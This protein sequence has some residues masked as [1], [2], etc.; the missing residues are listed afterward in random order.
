MD[1]DRSDVLFVGLGAT[2]VCY[3]RVLLPA[4][5]LGADYVGFYGEP[6]KLHYATGLVGGQSRVPDLRDYKLVVIQQPKG[7]E[8]LKIIEALRARGTVVCFEVDDYLHS[9]GHQADHAFRDAFTKRDLVEYERCMRAC[10][11]LI[12]STPYLASAY[13]PFN[14]RVYVCRN[15]IDLNRYELT[16]PPRATVNVGWAG[17]TGHARSLRAWLGGIADVMRARPQTYF[18]SIGRPFAR[19]L[20]PEFGPRAIA[21]PFAAVEQYPAAMTML[22]VAL[23]PGGRSNFQ[24]AKSDLRFLEAGALGIPIIADPAIYTDIQPRITGF[25]ARSSDEMKRQLLELVDDEQLRTTVGQN[26]RD[27]VREHRTIERAADGWRDA[28][29]SL[30]SSHSGRSVRTSRAAG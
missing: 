6:P 5:A 10:D 9:I 11:A 29:D 30:L 14:R 2:A 27:Y 18:L 12:V 13:R 15:G 26:A 3:Y 7:G 24:R 4:H 22:D 28:F 16:R 25:H 17:A 19:E 21:I 8:W 23:G 1:L 20:A